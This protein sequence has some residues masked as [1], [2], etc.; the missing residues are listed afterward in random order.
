MKFFFERKT[1][2]CSMEKKFDFMLYAKF[3]QKPVS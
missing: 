3:N 2:M 1:K